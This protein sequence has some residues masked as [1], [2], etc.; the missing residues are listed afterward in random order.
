MTQKVGGLLN[1]PAIASG[2]GK[3]RQEKLWCRS[4]E[5]NDE[6][7]VSN[8]SIPRHKLYLYRRKKPKESKK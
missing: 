1:G 5:N 4:D 6:S 2:G 3:P 7:D 8:V